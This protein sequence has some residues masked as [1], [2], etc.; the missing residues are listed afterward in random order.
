M[1]KKIVKKIYRIIIGLPILKIDNKKIV[2]DNF[3][4]KGFGGDPKYIALELIKGNVD[5]KMI[6]LVKNMNEQMP[7]QIKKVKYGSLKAYYELAT[8]KVW[9]DNVRN[10]KGVKKKKKQF[11]IQTWHGTLGLKKVEKEVEQSLPKEYVKAAKKDGKITNLMITNNDIETENFKKFF[12][13]DGPVLQIGL[14]KDD[15]LFKDNK[16]DITNKVYSYFNISE[17]KKIILYAPTFRKELDTNIYKFDI[18]KCR[19]ELEKKFKE[20]FIVLIRLH[21]NVASNDDC[22]EYNENIINATNYPDVQELLAV[23]DIGITDYSSISFELSMIGKK[24][25]LFCKDF[26]E[27]IRKERNL[28]FNIEQL[29]FPLA[30]NERELICNIKNFDDAKYKEE[31]SKF[32]KKINLIR[33]SDSAKKIVNIIKDKINKK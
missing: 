23:T 5:C 8:A 15:I 20:E 16:I 21:P 22:F 29:P 13:Y 25:L 28:N 31:F 9:I 6:W 26:E 24:V 7:E 4:G 14:P 10:N 27:Y 3:N 19:K 1:I 17:K 33:T 11:Y 30:K 12:W 32:Y 2:L 18:E